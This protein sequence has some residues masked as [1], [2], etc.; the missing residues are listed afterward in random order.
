MENITDRISRWLG[1]PCPRCPTP[2][3]CRAKGCQQKDPPSREPLAMPPG[4]LIPS[5]TLAVPPRRPSALQRM[6]ARGE[7]LPHERFQRNFTKV[8][9]N[10]NPQP[11]LDQL[12][13]H[14][15]LWNTNN[16]RT[17]KPYTAHHDVDD[18]IL[19]YP[20]P[21]VNQYNYPSFNVLSAALPI[22]MALMQAIHCEAL[23]RVLIS[24]L[25][26]GGIIGLH[27]DTLPGGLPMY[28]SRYQVPLQSKLG[29]RFICDGEEC[30]MEAGSIYWFN[31][32]LLHEVRNESDIDRISMVVD[33]RP[34]TPATIG[35]EHG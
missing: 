26:P 18:I 5:T 16:V 27:D 35:D 8:M 23:G 13:E 12:A 22:V 28:Y 14:P 20:R 31:N 2:D 32:T 6:R 25:P 4:L 30:N 7:L 33:A 34:F 24:R 1:S 21:N 19:R 15:E 9:Q 10:G 11:L 29:M 3:A 17:S